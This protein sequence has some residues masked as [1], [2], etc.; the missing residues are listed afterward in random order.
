[1]STTTAIQGID[2]ILRKL[3]TDAVAPLT[4]KPDIS[5]GPLDRD[6]DSLRLNWFL[7]RVVPDPT[8]R[9]MEPPRTG[10]RTARGSPPLA[11]RLS[12]LLSAFPAKPT[13]DGDQE[14]FA[15]AGLAVVMR[16]LHENGIIGESSSVLTPALAA[17]VK[18]LIEPLRIV[19]ETLDLEALTK[20]WTSAS[21][22][23]RLSVG[24]E[25]SVV[26]VQPTKLYV[27]GPPARTRRVAVSPTMG[28]RFVSV[29]PA[30]VSF[31]DDIDAEIAGLTAGAS[32]TLVHVREDPDGPDWPMTVLAGAP[33]GH[34]RL[35]LPDA[36][37][38]PGLRELDV[39]TSESGLPI[40]HDGTGLTV[41]PAVAG[42]ATPLAKGV[43]VTLQTVHATADV[44][45]FLRGR[46]VAPVTFVSP[47]QVDVTIPPAT[48]SGPAE[49]L[50]RAGKVA[51]PKR[52]VTVA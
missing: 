30:R 47:T 40:G 39:S 32:F 24:Y 6:D 2:D 14:Q 13:L 11:L 21:R 29:S 15:H 10:W 20:I 25:V 27:A 37:I 41:V 16:A 43:P 26:L 34:V 38:A 3:S 49:I 1:M 22:P 9:N 8:Y 50:L 28:P 33:P 44:E 36:R 46:P 42:P 4:P 18:P 31:G 23:I 45:V 12:Y 17:L 48:Q 35:K 7:Y 51:G 52:S 19:L 5:V